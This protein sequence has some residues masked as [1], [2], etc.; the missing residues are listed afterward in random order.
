MDTRR[1][2]SSR[3]APPSQ[4]RREAT[5]DQ[6]ALY[7]VSRGIGGPTKIGISRNMK[8]R[9]RSLQT[10]CA[11]EL[12]AGVSLICTHAADFERRVHQRLA[13]FR[14]KGEWFAVSP[15]VADA[16]IDAVL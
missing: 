9:M 14:L 2:A 5:V 6:I 10:G 3:R 13:A 12:R 11:E 4:R 16:A 8:A 1:I 7:T 15:A